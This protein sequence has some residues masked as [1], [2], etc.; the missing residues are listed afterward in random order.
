MENSTKINLKKIK[1][2]LKQAEANIKFEEVERHESHNN[3]NDK[4]KTFKR[5]NINDKRPLG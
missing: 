5:G 4:V 3:E 2:A 1:E